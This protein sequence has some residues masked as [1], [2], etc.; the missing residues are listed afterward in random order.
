MTVA[1]G[2]SK[3]LGTLNDTGVARDRGTDLISTDD[4]TNGHGTS[5]CGVINGG[6]I[7]M[8]KY[9][10]IAPDAELLVADRYDN[11]YTVYMPWAAANG[12]ESLVLSHD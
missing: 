12:A 10:G 9:V 7:G 5:V 11:D 3:V 1:L 8:R 6:T 4:D 2:T